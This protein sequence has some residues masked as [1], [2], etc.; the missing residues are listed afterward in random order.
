[1][2]TCG[3]TVGLGSAA[4]AVLAVAVAVGLAVAVDDPARPHPAAKIAQAKQATRV[5]P[6]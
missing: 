6:R 4:A 5:R 2:T 3:A 1:M